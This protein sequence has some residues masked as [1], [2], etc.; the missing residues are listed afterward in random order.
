MSDPYED[1]PECCCKGQE[2]NAAQAQEIDEL[3]AKLRYWVTMYYEDTGSDD[4]KAK[5]VLEE[6]L[7]VR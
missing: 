3:K 2:E 7:G 1:L 5:E 6:V 4:G